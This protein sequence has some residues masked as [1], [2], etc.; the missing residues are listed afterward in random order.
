MD[1][2]QWIAAT[3]VGTTGLVGLGTPVVSRLQ[4]RKADIAKHVHDRRADAYV[5]LLNALRLDLSFRLT[6]G[7]RP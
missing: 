3:A 2:G 5:E 7:L 1:T 4:Q 6:L